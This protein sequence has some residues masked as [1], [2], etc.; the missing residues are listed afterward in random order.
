MP[1]QPIKTIIVCTDLLR[2]LAALKAYRDRLEEVAIFT[3]Y[4]GNH[5][6]K[7]I[8]DLLGDICSLKIGHIAQIP[9][10]DS[11]EFPSLGHMLIPVMAC[12][13]ADANG[14]PEVVSDLWFAQTDSRVQVGATE[15]AI[16]YA[17]AALN[18]PKLAITTPLMDLPLNVIKSDATDF[19]GESYTLHLEELSDDGTDRSALTPLVA[20]LGI[21][22]PEDNTEAIFALAKAKT[23]QVI[24]QLSTEA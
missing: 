23:E 9:T 19:L 3:V 15:N 6:L 14:I 11:G 4:Y 20:E 5:R 10:H 2:T 7:T 13:F 17:L 18:R 16:N 8:T 1:N 21:Q 22:L 24:E 12:N